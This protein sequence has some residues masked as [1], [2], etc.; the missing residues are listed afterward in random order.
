MPFNPQTPDDVAQMLGA[1]G[2]KTID[3][4]F[5]EIPKNLRIE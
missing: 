5:D 2:V 3:D 4:L 1:I